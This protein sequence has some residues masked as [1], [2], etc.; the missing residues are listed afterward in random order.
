MLRT[1]RLLRAFLA[2][3]GVWCILVSITCPPATARAPAAPVPGADWIDGVRTEARPASVPTNPAPSPGRE[4]DARAARLARVDHDLAEIEALL[5]SAHFRTALAVVEP[6][7]DLLDAAGEDRRL[8][9]RRAR[10][11]VMAATAQAALGRHARARQSMIRALRAD[12]ALDLDAGQT[13]PKVLKLL[14][15]ARLHTGIA[16]PKP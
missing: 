5:A 14:R 15:E 13:S 7:R 10:L 11:E 6:T 1:R 4:A 8:G 9:T 2:H 3:A 12:P 16:E